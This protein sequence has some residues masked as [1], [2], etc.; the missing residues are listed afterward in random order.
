V[1]QEEIIDEGEGVKVDSVFFIIFQY[2]N[3][4]IKIEAI[5]KKEMAEFNSLTNTCL[6]KQEKIRKRGHVLDR[7]YESRNQFLV[8]FPALGSGMNK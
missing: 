1:K 3:S 4:A 8:S 5:I 2:M 7:L 6:S